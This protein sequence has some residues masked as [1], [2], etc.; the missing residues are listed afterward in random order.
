MRICPSCGQP[1]ERHARFRS[2]P[3]TGAPVRTKKK[4]RG[5]FRLCPIRQLTGAELSK[6]ERPEQ[7]S[8]YPTIYVAAPGLLEKVEKAA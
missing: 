2:D 4:G 1:K 3:L 8:T 7:A 6:R 5:I